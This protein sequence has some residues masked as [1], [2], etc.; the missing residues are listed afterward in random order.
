M[1]YMRIAFDNHFFRD[2][3][4]AG[5]RNATDVIP[6]EIDQHQML[7]QFFRIGEQV[8]FHRNIFIARLAAWTGSGNRSNRDD[9][10]FQTDQHFG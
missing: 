4:C 9:I 7:R 1:H 3:H 2:L 8:L 10:V 5:G 6:A